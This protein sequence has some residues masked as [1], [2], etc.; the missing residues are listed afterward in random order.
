MVELLK[1]A[2]PPSAPLPSRQPRGA[3]PDIGGVT[4]FVR[5]SSVPTPVRPYSSSTGTTADVLVE[6]RAGFGRDVKQY[7]DVCVSILNRSFYPSTSSTTSVRA[8]TSTL[9]EIQALSRYMSH[10]C[11]KSEY[12]NDAYVSGQSGTSSMVTKTT[13]PRHTDTALSRSKQSE[14]TQCPFIVPDTT[15][16]THTL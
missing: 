16:T 2:P 13:T 9:R 7:M 8:D 11:T 4:F 1:H 3:T 12:I 5:H 15:G 10:V 6:R 14:R